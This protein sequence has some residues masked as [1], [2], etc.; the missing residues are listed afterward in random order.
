MH[1]AVRLGWPSRE[2]GLDHMDA[3]EFADWIVYFSSDANELKSDE[4]IYDEQMASFAAMRQ[5]TK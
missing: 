4:Q 3:I 5:A 1:L 2:W